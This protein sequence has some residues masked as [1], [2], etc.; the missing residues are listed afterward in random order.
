MLQQNRP[1]SLSDVH[2]ALDFGDADPDELVLPGTAASA[3][4]GVI[5]DR[6]AVNF[7]RP[8][9]TGGEKSRTGGKRT[10]TFT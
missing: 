6:P 8:G 5:D 9:Q 4:S 3:S 2:A 7:A 1:K 10:A